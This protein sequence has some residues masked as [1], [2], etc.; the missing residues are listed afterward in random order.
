MLGSLELQL[1][2]NFGLG[3]R[4]QAPNTK[5]LENF[6]SKCFANPVLSKRN[7]VLGFKVWGL[8]AKAPNANY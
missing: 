6:I 1:I 5:T 8:G 3:F 7:E 2:R 4:Y